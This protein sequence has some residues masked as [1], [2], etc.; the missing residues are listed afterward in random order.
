M[1]KTI[2]INITYPNEMSPNE[3][4]T[5]LFSPAIE[6]LN[7]TDNW[8][9]EL[10]MTFDEI[11]ERAR[12]SAIEVTLSDFPSDWTNEQIMEELEE[13]EDIYENENI[14]VWEPYEGWTGISVAN[15]IDGLTDV[16]MSAFK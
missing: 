8:S 16:I 6:S 14:L 3:L 15:H 9:A 12:R 4:I 2:V 11:E 1:K 13:S 7:A 10:L 5:E